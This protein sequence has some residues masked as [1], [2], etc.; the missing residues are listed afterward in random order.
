M[1][2]VPGLHLDADFINEF[3]PRPSK[4]GTGRLHVQ[5]PE[6]HGPGATRSRGSQET[7]QSRAS[8]SDDA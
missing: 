8:T 1:T 7:R 2:S 5:H 4:R 3:H 6:A